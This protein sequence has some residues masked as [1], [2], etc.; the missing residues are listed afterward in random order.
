MVFSI[1]VALRLTCTGGGGGSA[2]DWIPHHPR[3]VVLSLQ[4][5]F[6]AVS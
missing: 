1:A 4:A 6:L 5:K 3:A 2:P